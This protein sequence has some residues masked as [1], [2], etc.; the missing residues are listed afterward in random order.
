MKKVRV[1]LADDHKILLAGLRRLLESDVEVISAVENGKELLEETVR[2]KP[3]IVITD[4][5]MPIMKGL[6]VLR[7]IRELGLRTKAIFLT[8]HSDVQFVAEAFEMGASG[9]VLKQAAVEELAV[10]IREVA[11]GRVYLSEHLL[12]RLFQQAPTSCG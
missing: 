8:M 7:H 9:Y 12:I 3:D 10:A 1:S 5:S 2:L 11:E 4:I 6:D